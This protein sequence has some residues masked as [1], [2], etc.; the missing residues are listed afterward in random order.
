MILI[1]EEVVTESWQ[2]VA[3]LN[4]A[5]VKAGIR[6]FGQRQ[7]ALLAYALGNSKSLSTAAGELLVYMAF[8]VVNA[9][10]LSGAKVRQVSPVAIDATEAAL[11]ERLL[12]LQGAHDAFIAR[13]AS[14][15]ASNQP[16]LFAYLVETLHE[17]PFEPPDPVP[18]TPEEQGAIFLAIATVIS[19]L[20]QQ[21]QSSAPPAV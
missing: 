5:Q 19:A 12:T 2:S 21:R 11:E 1:P 16:Y 14:L 6:R 17:A 18:L 13:A 15:L 8:V 10:Y 20:D 3:Q 9:V 7:P 4:P